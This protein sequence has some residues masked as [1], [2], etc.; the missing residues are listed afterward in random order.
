MIGQRHDSKAQAAACG[1]HQTSAHKSR[2]RSCS[3]GFGKS[4]ASPWNPSLGKALKFRPRV[5]DRADIG[6]AGGPERL[7]EPPRD[8]QTTLRIA[9]QSAGIAPTE[10][11][12]RKA[13]KLERD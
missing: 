11:V 9:L 2:T 7:R 3:T 4:G 10:R 12:K 13:R 5:S 6:S 1:V 8:I